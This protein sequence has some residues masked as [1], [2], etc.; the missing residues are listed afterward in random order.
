MGDTEILGSGSDR[1][2]GGIAWR[3]IRTNEGVVTM[4]HLL[5]DAKTSPYPGGRKRAE[6]RRIGA[7][8]LLGDKKVGIR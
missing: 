4:K 8:A 6:N 2:W 1:G 3:E 5:A 7:P